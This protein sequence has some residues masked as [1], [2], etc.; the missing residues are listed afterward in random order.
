L[1][2]QAARR[3]KSD[4]FRSR[5]LQGRKRAMDFALAGCKDGKERWI[6]LSQAARTEKSDEFCS[7]RLQGPKKTMIL[8]HEWV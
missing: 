1:L 8:A 2:S 3:E 5:K 7:R 4:E 6:S